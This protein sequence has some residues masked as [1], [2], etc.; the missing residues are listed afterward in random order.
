[1]VNPNKNL[2]EY[3]WKLIERYANIKL[4]KKQIDILVEWK[5]PHRIDTL[6]KGATFFKLVET[7]FKRLILLELCLLVSEKESFNIYKWLAKVKIHSKSLK[8]TRESKNN[9]AYN[10]RVVIKNDEYLKIIDKHFSNLSA[11]NKTIKK[12][13][14]LREKIFTHYDAS[15]FNNSQAIYRKYSI[16]IF[17]LDS[18]MKTIEKILTEQHSYLFASS[19]TNFDVHSYSNVDKIL[20]Y[21][22]AF[23]RIR[24]DKSLIMDKGFK[25]VD[26]LKE[27]FPGT[28]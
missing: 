7:S 22:R 8:P 12:L 14:A 6:N 13:I 26:Y 28:E 17:E 9:Q 16:D 11:Q 18:L 20:L 15:Y 19:I 5:G 10:T 25:P 24:K 3:L 2:S 23:M 21:T 1:M 27:I 4:Y